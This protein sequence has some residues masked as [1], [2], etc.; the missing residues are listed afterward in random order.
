MEI[1]TLAPNLSVKNVEETIEYYTK[2]LGFDL[3]VTVPEIKPFN[4]AMVQSGP[5]AFMFQEV[6]NLKEEYPLLEKFPIGGGLTFYINVV[7]VRATFN[8]LKG[9]VK[10]VKELNKTFYGAT[11]FVIEDCNGYVLTFSQNEN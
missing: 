8:E 11:E 5:V 9:K 7:D 3:V 6:G 2:T 4:W 1:K 10:I